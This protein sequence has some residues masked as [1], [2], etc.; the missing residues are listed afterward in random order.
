MYERILKKDMKK[1]KEEIDHELPRVYF[2]FI[3]EAS[4]QEL[5]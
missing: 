5:L 2:T 1:K 4:C 3:H